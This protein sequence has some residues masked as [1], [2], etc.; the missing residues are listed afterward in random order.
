M[1]QRIR[2]LGELARLRDE[3]AQRAQDEA[4]RRREEAQ[5]RQREGAAANEFKVAV[6]ALGDVKPLAPHGRRHHAP[7][8]HPPHP[9]Q[10]QL[11]ERQVL[12]QSVSD[13]IDLES[14]LD[15]DEALSYRRPGIGPDVLR[16]LRRGDWVI[17]GSK[18]R[19]PVLKGKVRAWLV[20]RDEVIAFCQA[21]AAEG[22]SGA[23][24][25]LLRPSSAAPAPKA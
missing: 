25:V 22:G 16:R 7:R 2:G 6:E 13:E 18:D 11:D 4:R 14:L 24:V 1:A 9:K 5:Q 3:L 10:R 23:L 15:T 20:Q 12:A 17:H 8:P 21:R 19:Q